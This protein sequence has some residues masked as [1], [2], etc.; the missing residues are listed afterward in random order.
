MPA[1]D[2]PA[3]ACRR[4]AATA[5]STRHSAS[6]QVV[7]QA[8]DVGRL[9]GRVDRG[10]RGAVERA[11]SE[12][13]RAV[14]QLDAGE[15]PRAVGDHVVG[16]DRHALAEH[17]QARSTCVLSPIRTPPPT[18]Q[19]LS[20]Q[21][22]PISAPRMTTARSIV[23]CGADHDAG[24]EH[25]AAAHAGAVG[26]PAAALDE[27]GRDDPAL[28]LDASARPRGSRRRRAR[29]TRSRPCPRGCRTSP[30]GSARASRC[31][32]S[33][34]RSRS[35]RGR[36]RRAAGRRRARS[37]RAGRA[38]SR[39]STRALEHVGAGGDVARVDLVVRRASP[40]TR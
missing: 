2:Q 30:R 5:A 23:V 39:S 15:D 8:E 16:A 19:P 17:R 27:R 14:R 22:S 31:R 36:C 11:P 37:R 35:R 4:A 24:L 26:D 18:M 3:G 38:P 6:S 13:D 28:A 9:A 20:V 1:I 10:H 32:A 25:D 7:R 33:S 40:R 12:A 21:F 29:R 34:S